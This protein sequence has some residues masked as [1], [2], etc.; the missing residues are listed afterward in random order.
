[1]TALPA[2]G[3]RAEWSSRGRRWACSRG[4]PPGPHLCWRTAAWRTLPVG[5]PS[6]GDC[7]RR[8]RLHVGADFGGV[9]LA[10]RRRGGAGA[11]DLAGL[12]GVEVVLPLADHDRG[13]G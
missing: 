6:R 1:M 5:M 3:L 11:Q 13:D 4:G 7:T 8:A 9:Q 10:L 2:A 12:F